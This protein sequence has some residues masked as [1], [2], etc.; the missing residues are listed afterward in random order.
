M[1]GRL[2]YSR[3]DFLSENRFFFGRSAHIISS[4]TKSEAAVA[5]RLP[6]Q[7]ADPDESAGV[8]LWLAANA[9]QRRQR[10]ALAELDLTHPQFLL[11]AGV[12]WLT[13]EGEPITQVRL[14]AHV[15]ADPMMTS[16][17]VRALE[18]KRLVRRLAH[19]TD[20]RA[21]LLKATARGRKLAR[22]AVVVAERIDREFFAAVDAERIKGAL[23]EVLAG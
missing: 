6:P 23:R 3:N 5:P 16:Q 1:I 14:A 11:L 18:K 20:T 22:L 9:W 2:N 17:I 7:Y 21:R 4:L 13:R 19:P 15:H 8:L 12:S 10:A